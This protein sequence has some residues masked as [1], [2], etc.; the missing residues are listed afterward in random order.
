V[1]AWVS[2]QFPQRSQKGD[3]GVDLAGAVWRKSTYSN[4]N[5]CVEVAFA[6]GQIAVRDSKDRSG[7][8]LRFTSLEWWAF[9]GGVRHGEFDLPLCALLWPCGRT[10]YSSTCRQPVKGSVIRAA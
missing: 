2:Q 3:V 4:D 9:V 5:G 7:P 10:C 8:I 6:N 1:A